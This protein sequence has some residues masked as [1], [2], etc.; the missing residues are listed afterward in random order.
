MKK[1]ETFCEKESHP[2]KRRGDLTENL[3]RMIY[4]HEIRDTTVSKP[5]RNQKYTNHMTISL[6]SVSIS[7]ILFLDV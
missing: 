6:N 2:W 3:L 1:K 7:F 5:K 4:A